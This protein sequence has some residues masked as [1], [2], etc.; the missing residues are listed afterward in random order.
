MPS[1]IDAPVVG[2]AGVLTLVL[3]TVAVQS[4]MALL[5]ACGALLTLAV[6]FVVPH[7]L[8]LG[9]GLSA[10]LAVLTAVPLNKLDN[11]PSLKIVIPGAV[12]GVLLASLGRRHATLRITR[13]L[14]LLACTYVVVACGSLITGIASPFYFMAIAMSLLVLFVSSNCGRD[15]RELVTLVVVLL[16][17]VEVAIAL[18][19]VFVNQ[20]PLFVS[21]GGLA[22]Y[23]P[24]LPD[25][26]LR[27]E[28]TLGHPLVLGYFFLVGFALVLRV[29]WPSVWKGAAGIGLCAGLVLSGSSSTL[30]AATVA[31]AYALWL[32]YRGAVRLAL[33]YLLGLGAAFALSAGFLQSVLVSDVSSASHYGHRVASLLAVGSLLTE[34]A[35]PNVLLGNGADSATRLYAAGILP[36]DGF[37]AIDN[38]LVTMLAEGGL[39]ALLLFSA[40]LWV[41]VRTASGAAKPV[42]VVLLV[43]MFSFDVLAWYIP[44]MATLV[45][46]GLYCTVPLSDHRR[47]YG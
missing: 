29:Q 15:E 18:F 16:G 33:V 6:L 8:V 24:Y 17:L 22:R 46:L 10:A 45:V 28:G 44:A 42:V 31:T 11:D 47:V 14:V 21:T 19:E 38:Q 41:T 3:T 30:I 32:R 2:V 37:Y 36:D 7:D 25:G 34:R 40:F 35:P 13:M 12:A 27:A 26:T 1:A 20:G 43:M 5:L 23:N 9:L 4:P 39:L